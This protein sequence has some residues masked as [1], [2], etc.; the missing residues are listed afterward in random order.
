MTR[1][2]KRTRMSGVALR[3][4]AAVEVLVKLT[5]SGL[6]WPAHLRRGTVT[7]VGRHR[8]RVLFPIRAFY[9]FP[10]ELLRV[11]GFDGDGSAV[12]WR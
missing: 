4:G 12:G 5:P 8:A 2:T 11:V 3:K 6:R 7:Q 1:M 10:R 9:W